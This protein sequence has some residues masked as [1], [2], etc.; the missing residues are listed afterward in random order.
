MHAVPECHRCMLIYKVHVLLYVL[1]V[2]LPS[3]KQVILIPYMLR[4]YKYEHKP[5]LKGLTQQQWCK[6][7]RMFC[8]K[9]EKLRLK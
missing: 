4:N 1:I 7:K 2:Y 3:R 5:M 8:K 9:I 6:L